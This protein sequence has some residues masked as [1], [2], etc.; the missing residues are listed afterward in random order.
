MSTPQAPPPGTPEVAVLVPTLAAPRHAFGWPPGSI[1]SILTLLVVGLVC[2]LILMAK[3][4]KGEVIRIPPYLIYLLFLAVGYY[5]AARGHGHPVPKNVPPPLY[6]PRG[7]VRLII[8][9]ALMA[10][11]GWK[12]V[13]NDR[14]V[15]EQQL[16]ESFETVKEQAL[17][18]L[19]VLGGFFLGVIFRGVVIRGHERSPWAQDLEAWFAL[20]A[21]LLMCVSAMIHLVIKPNLTTPIDLAT[22]EGILAGVVAFYF[23]IRS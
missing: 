9:V 19:V 17:L 5:F 4:A 16:R 22:F 23:G 15:L 20:I 3:D 2:S 12:I 11:V 21:I 14:A 18:P 6:L 7:S 10:T 13:N 1:R 8:L